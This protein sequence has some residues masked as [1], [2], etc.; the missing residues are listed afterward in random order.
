MNAVLEWICVADSRGCSWLGAGVTDWTTANADSL[1]EIV[2]L[3]IGPQ[4]YFVVCF[5]VHLA[6]SQ[7]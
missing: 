7:V 2:K 5:V 3:T 4:V 1:L 6:H